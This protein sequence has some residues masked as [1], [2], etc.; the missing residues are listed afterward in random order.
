MKDGRNEK[1]EG[2]VCNIQHKL[3]I[4]LKKGEKHELLNRIRLESPGLAQIVDFE[5][6]GMKICE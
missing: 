6:D 5:L 1:C 4:P 2:K 3:K